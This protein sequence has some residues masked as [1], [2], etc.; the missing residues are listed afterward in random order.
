MI[1]PR[2]AVY[3]ALLAAAGLPIYIHG[4][5]FF[6]DTYG[7]DLGDIGV[8]LLLLRL[9]DVLQDPFFGRLASRLSPSGRQLG[10]IVAAFGMASGMLGLF[11]FVAPIEPII[12]MSL[13][14]FLLFSSFSFLS[15]LFYARGVMEG[16]KLGA[17]GHVRL[18]GWRE[19]GGLIGISFATMAPFLFAGKSGSGF[20]AFSLIFAVFVVFAAW[21]MHSIWRGPIRSVGT[22]FGTILSDIEI[23]KL[24]ALAFVNSAPIAVTSSLFLFFV[25]DRLGA[26]QL[27]GPLLLGFFIAAALA[28]PIWSRAAIRFGTVPTLAAGMVLSVAAFGWAYNLGSEDI[29]AFTIVCFASGAALGADMTLLPAIFSNRIKEIGASG[30]EA[31]GLWNF[32]AKLTLAISAASVLP[33]LDAAGFVPGGINEPEALARLSLLYA[34]LPCLLKLIAIS[35]LFSFQRNKRGLDPI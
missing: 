3:S 22:G 11:H 27:A 33:L 26:P 15:I 31:F 17:N 8:A 10:A 6:V 29:F 35:I 23:R 7:V 18:A 21:I 1:L 28:V 13:C 25:S 24:L 12:W 4:P 14:L 9:I 20:G 2:Y 30:S 16:A 19:A 5:K 34:A 32:A